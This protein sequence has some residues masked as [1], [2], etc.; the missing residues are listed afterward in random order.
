MINSCSV[1]QEIPGSRVVQVLSCG[2]CVRVEDG[3]AARRVIYIDW[4]SSYEDEKTRAQL[5]LGDWTPL[6]IDD[7]YLQD[8][9]LKLAS[10]EAKNVRISYDTDVV[11]SGRYRVVSIGGTFGNV[12]PV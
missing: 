11:E 1:N 8:V 5:T 12:L 7:L 3:E 4:Q 6:Y 9:F 2:W 10:Y